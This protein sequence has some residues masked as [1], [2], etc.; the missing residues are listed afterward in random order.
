[1]IARFMARVDALEPMTVALAL[2]I[3]AI[4]FF[5]ELGAMCWLLNRLGNRKEKPP[6][7]VVS[8]PPTNAERHW[9]SLE[10][11]CDF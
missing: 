3:C 1:V 4:V 11:R 8:F 6:T 7:N 2:F 9:R 10:G 5:S